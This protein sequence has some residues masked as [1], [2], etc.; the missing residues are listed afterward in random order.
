MAEERPVVLNEWSI[1]WSSS[2]GRERIVVNELSF[3]LG[4][5]EVLVFCYSIVGRVEVLE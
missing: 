2:A 3:L 1:E 5:V 4:R